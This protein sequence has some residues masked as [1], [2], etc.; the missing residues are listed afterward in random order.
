[1]I[2]FQKIVKDKLEEQNLYRIDRWKY[3]DKKCKHG[4]EIFCAKC[5]DEIREQK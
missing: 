5:A 2:D 4:N 3:P 1:M